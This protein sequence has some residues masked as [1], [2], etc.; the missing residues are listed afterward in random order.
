M[1]LDNNDPNI[2]LQAGQIPQAF[3]QGFSGAGQNL[4]QLLALQQRAQQLRQAQQS[5]NALRTMF[6][7]PKNIDET[8][9]PTKNALAQYMQA[10]PKGGLNMLTQ[11]AQLDEHQS[12]GQLMKSEVMQSLQ[13]DAHQ[14]RQ[15]AITRYDE[16]IGNGTSPQAATAVVQK[17][18]YTPWYDNAKRGGYSP[19]IM[20]TISPQFDINRAR[21]NDK[22]YEAANTKPITPYQKAELG[23]KESADQRAN[24][25]LGIKAAADERAQTEERR[26]QAQFQRGDTANPVDVEITKPDGKKEYGTAVWD[27]DAKRYVSTDGTKT[28]IEG[29]VR[30]VSTA[31]LATSDALDASAEE[32]ANY[33]APP[34]TSFAMARGQGPEIM[35][36]IR[37][38]NPD[39]NA[40]KYQVAQRVRNDFA[41][42]AQ[43]AKRVDAMNTVVHHLGV[44]DDLAKG[45]GNHDIN[46][47]NRVLNYARTELGRPE[48]T[49]FNV[50][51]GIIGDEVIKAVVGSG[52]VFDRESLQKDLND[53]R[54]PEQ[55]QKM[56]NRIRQLMGGSLGA[57]YQR[58]HSV[59]LP[60]DEF[61][62]KLEPETVE[63][64]RGFAPTT[65]K[66]ALEAGGEEKSAP[67]AGK[68]VAFD[69][70]APAKK[71]EAPP[72]EAFGGDER[73]T[74][75]NEHG[76]SYR[77]RGGTVVKVN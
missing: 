43:S 32:I 31:N 2:P 47:M 62:A 30:Q 50:A 6:G 22:A 1:P 3:Q 23:F 66:K 10:D 75:T 29:S 12:R 7:D 34:L 76:E 14:M 28:P 68:A 36:R 8:G 19:Q 71:G 61:V 69:M 24:V 74:L 21:T 67:A 26:R 63:G 11:L 35:K 70:N 57:L 56:S 37:E 46:A 40:Q 4:N 27:K 5:E 55:L 18:I 44:F 9:R 53:A 45:L 48:V 33:K 38:I 59:P 17:E 72:A 42:G 64:V 54:S 60:D 15:Q 41:S 77:L 52:A 13:K 58:W 39:W 51:K 20:D 73:K 49:D 16:L 25:E 65:L